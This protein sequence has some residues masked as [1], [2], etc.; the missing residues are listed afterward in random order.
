M[1]TKLE[2]SDLTGALIALNLILTLARD[3]WKLINEVKGE[4]PIPTWDE[5][6]Q[7]QVDLGELIEEMKRRA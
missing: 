4:A 2:A 7:G 6:L 3:L 5:I 1:A